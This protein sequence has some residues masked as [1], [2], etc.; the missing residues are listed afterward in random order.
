MK[1]EASF[2]THSMRWSRKKRSG[3]CGHTVNT[4]I[5]HSC[6]FHRKNKSDNTS[7]NNN[8]DDVCGDI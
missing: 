7:N 3:S 5:A 1:E 8:D 2:R 4:Y 6:V